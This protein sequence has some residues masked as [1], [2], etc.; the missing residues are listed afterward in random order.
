MANVNIPVTLSIDQIA[1]VEKLTKELNKATFKASFNN[2]GDSGATTAKGFKD[3]EKS[4]RSVNALV[5]QFFKLRQA[6]QENTAIFQS[7]ERAI[8]KIP[9]KGKQLLNTVLRVTDAFKRLSTETDTASEGF[10]K[11]FDELTSSLQ[12]I[13]KQAPTL[14][15]IIEKE[16][17]STV[18]KVIRNQK[19]ATKAVLEESKKR[20]DFR[21]R[22][23]RADIQARLNAE[24]K[25]E[26]SAAQQ[27]VASVTRIEK[28][29]QKAKDEFN[30][31]FDARQNDLQGRAGSAA[32]ADASAL[33]KQDESR[34]KNL[35]EDIK[36]RY[37]ILNK[38]E[39]AAFARQLDA[40][41]NVALT[42]GNEARSIFQE[43]KR[44][45]ASLVRSGIISQED[46]D[47]INRRFSEI[48]AKVQEINRIKAK[49]S[50]QGTIAAIGADG[51]ALARE[52]Q[53]GRDLVNTLNQAKTA[54]EQRAVAQKEQE[55]S[56]KR[57][58]TLEERNNEIYRQR[59]SVIEKQ[60][61]LARETIAIANANGRLANNPSEELRRLERFASADPRS[62]VAVAPPGGGPPRPPVVGGGPEDFFSD[63][64]AARRTVSRL[65][66]VV[67]Q[68]AK[69]NGIVQRFG[70]LTGLAAKRYGAFLL[71]TFA[72]TRLTSA[73]AAANQEA[74]Q[75]EK[76]IGRLSQTIRVFNDTLDQARSRGLAVG[77]AILEAARR[78]G[79]ASNEIAQGVVEIAQAGNEQLGALQFVA[80]QLANTQL[81]ASFDD[82]K[83]TAEGLI[84]V[85][86]QFNLQLSDTGNLLD[87]INQVSVEYAVES[88]NFFEAV[89][90]GGATFAGL[91]G[92]FE[93]FIE[94]LTLIRSATRETAPTL[95]VF[96]KTGLGRL[97]KRDQQAIFRE[98]GI[99]APDGERTVIDQ[100]RELAN[101]RQFQSL[102]D[103]ER[104]RTTIGLAGAQ[105]SG[106]LQKLLVE[107]QQESVRGSTVQDVIGASTGSVGRDIKIVEEDVNR[108]IGRITQSFQSLFNVLL[109]D[110]TVRT[111]FKSFADGIANFTDFVNDNKSLVNFFVRL[112]A[113]ITTLTAALTGLRFVAGLRQGITGG[114]NTIASSV[115]SN[116]DGLAG[117]VRGERTLGRNGNRFFSR[118]NVGGFSNLANSRA[119]R[120]AGFA[121]V[122]TG[123]TLLPF[124][125]NQGVNSSSNRSDRVLGG[126]ASTA[127][128]FGGIGALLGSI[129]PGVGTIAGAISGGILGAIVGAIDTNSDV[130]SENTRSILDRSFLNSNLLESTGRTRFS[131]SFN[132][133][134]ASLTASRNNRFLPSVGAAVLGR[135]DFFS[136]SEVTSDFLKENNSRIID[137]LSQSVNELSFTDA[138]LADPKLI[139]QKIA[140][141]AS[142]ILNE[143]FNSNN[144]V[145][146]GQDIS[147]IVRKFAFEIFNV[148]Q[149]QT[150]R[151]LASDA[152][153]RNQEAAD[154]FDFSE[155]GAVIDSNKNTFSQLSINLG[156]ISKGFEK[157]KNSLDNILTDITSVRDISLATGDS[158]FRQSIGLQLGE[159]GQLRDQFVQDANFLLGQNAG[160]F[161]D[162]LDFLFTTLSQLEPPTS[163]PA[164]ELEIV[165]SIDNLV[166]NVLDGLSD[167][168]R[169]ATV[170]VLGTL[171]T[172]LGSL[173]AAIEQL[174]S[175]NFN[176]EESGDSV[177]QIKE[178]TDRLREIFKEFGDSVSSLN[179][180]ILERSNKLQELFGER[181]V[182]NRQI[183]TDNI[184]RQET[185]ILRTENR[186]VS[187]R[188]GNFFNTER[189]FNFNPSRINGSVTRATLTSN[190]GIA[191]DQLIRSQAKFDEL[192][193]SNASPQT[194]AEQQSIV[195]QN[196]IAYNSALQNV[197][198]RQSD[199]GLLLDLASKAVSSFREAL[200]KTRGGLRSLGQVVLQT[201]PTELRNQGNLLEGFRRFITNSP[202]GLDQGIRNSVGR[203][204]SPEQAQELIKALENFGNLPIAKDAAGILT[205]QD[206]INIILE[207]IALRSFGSASGR[208][209]AG[210]NEIEELL[211]QQQENVKLA[212]AREKELQDEQRALQQALL[213]AN[214]AAADALGNNSKALDRNKEA[215]DKL[216]SLLEKQVQSVS[217]NLSNPSQA[218]NF[219]NANLKVEV[220]DIKV[221]FDTDNLQQFGQNAVANAL[222]RVG[223]VLTDLYIDEP[224]KLAKV[225]LLNVQADRIT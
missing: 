139:Q 137:I 192:R 201:D 169:D 113:A 33:Q 155:I 46:F 57:L 23:L 168:V 187:S 147:E 126:A 47:V 216:T 54:A 84:A 4:A 153:K 118:G 115:S 96:F 100:I 55:A 225:K 189:A 32:N 53:N 95:G 186:D 85:Q 180:K 37:T 50:D 104:I 209:R 39:Q 170:N 107:L 70:E 106:R 158:D 199:L 181:A 76:L 125:A 154:V 40:V 164:A 12:L 163:G 122:G 211:R 80:D 188:L 88:G 48:A 128:S 131:S 9:G 81:S 132:R 165:D 101:N 20:N 99:D 86:G 130:T 69:F 60:Q 79:V 141:N 72:I 210:R 28:E 92:T 90:R 77:D 202:N 97:T 183:L 52:V 15:R 16:I 179:Q 204:G 111:F 83:S 75:F 112:T 66:S 206:A 45:A 208:G 103:T 89:K 136:Q 82:I 161:A 91:G 18:D 35:R 2:I 78:T 219:L 44:Q 5:T 200:D 152:Q 140:Q 17:G 207:E 3:L 175:G 27:Y 127:A 116:V 38:E 21:V 190:L 94:Y 142:K 34:A 182:I 174:I 10:Q 68:Q 148:D 30:K 120:G 71:G 110:K 62:L 215:L 41:R 157:F 36:S 124:L 151:K 98:F 14:K 73:F 144:N 143:S 24:V 138:E 194:L 129:I 8:E 58:A 191:N 223:Q 114:I 222:N 214:N 220:E 56:A 184:S 31:A 172:S 176:P 11:D 145:Q 109:Q 51:N 177:F 19:D 166:N 221:S 195:T 203:L 108:S 167:P 224:E 7:V 185:D 74:L 178:I 133:D 42:S 6:G 102:S 196:L 156:F 135:D 63:D 197:N 61:A 213:D 64:D 212:Q 218:T 134:I 87:K 171:K 105:Q 159:T 29:V 1:G 13:G 49:D 217:N 43:A 193:Q 150:K 65:R 149:E 198:E 121:A 26:E 146:I 67:A 117:L 22:Q 205:G 119:V 25:A 123:L 160:A 93:E 59:I 162:E 173:P